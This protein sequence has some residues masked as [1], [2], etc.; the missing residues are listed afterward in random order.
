MTMKQSRWAALDEFRG[1][2][3]LLLII[4]NGFYGFTLTPGW[5]DHAPAGHY[6][7]ADLIAPLFLFAVGLAYPLSLRKRRERDGR[8]AAAIHAIRRGVTLIAFGA[9]GDCLIAG[10]G[11]PV[12]NW[13]TLEMIGLC[14]IAAFPMLDWKPIYRILAGIGSLV[15]WQN[16]LGFPHLASSLGVHYDMGGPCAVL[17]WMSIVL[18]ASAVCDWRST[19]APA[20]YV[21]RVL[22]TA[23]AIA[24]LAWDALHFAVVSK[25]SVSS[26]YILVSLAGCFAFFF[27]FSLKEGFAV[28][29]VAL[30]NSL[31]K[32]AL[33][34]YMVSGILNKLATSAVG[35]SV[36]L[37]LLPVVA[38]IQACIM[39]ALGLSMD[40]K[41]IIIAL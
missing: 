21:L 10:P 3:V 13:G 7:I 29:P 15:V 30:L 16:I 32:N 39:I 41:K 6:H 26:S 40:R 25:Y 28:R 8:T 38:L 23:A 19:C 14:C 18:I 22:V 4:F 37:I 5:L 34:L 9:V 36:P 27:L 17:S 20:R 35:S 11:H 31:G 1:F 33:V 2:A 12:F 24:V